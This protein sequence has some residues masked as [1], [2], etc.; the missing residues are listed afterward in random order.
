M[1]QLGII[2]SSFINLENPATP[3]HI[4]GLGLYDPATAP[5]GFV[6]F[7]DVLTN[8]D[9]RLSQ[10]PLFR[11]RLVEVAGG[12]DRPYWIEDDSYDVEFHIRHIA[13]PKPGD[14]R[15]LWI[16]VARLHSRPL[17]M[18][19]PLW[20]AYVIE[21]LDNIKGLP[22]GAFAIYTKMHHSLVDGSGGA[23][24]ISVI[25]DL[26]PA[27]NYPDQTIRVVSDRQPTQL[28]LVSRSMINRF[29]NAKQSATGLT[30][31][32]GKAARYG[33]AVAKNEKQVA[34]TA[35]KTRFN[36]RVG[37]H[38]VADAFTCE[39]EDLK[40]IK[41]ATG[42]T[43]NDVCLTIVSGGMRNYLAE[44]KEL[45]IDSLVAGIPLDMRRRL[46][47]NDDKNQVGSTFT[48]MHTNIADPLERL[49]AV[50]ASTQT[51]KDEALDNPMLEMISVP[52][53]IAPFFAKPLARLWR[54][55]NISDFIPLNISTVVTNVPGPNFPLYCAGAE[56]VRYHGLGLLTP[57]CGLF[58]TIFSSNGM[59][60]LTVLADRG[61]MPDPEIYINCLRDAFTELH[62]A[63]VGRLPG[64]AP[65]TSRNVKSPNEKSSSAAAIDSGLSKR[66]KTETTVKSPRATAK[67]KSASVAT[68]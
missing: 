34:L 39:L 37:P 3:Q 49:H 36:N 22:K 50:K 45:P 30:S 19:R 31:R 13:L 38:R 5:D 2:D 42:T 26:V 44:K 55:N 14:W 47:N 20:E 16:Q 51:A 9:E 12:L 61:I 35:P 46:G 67:K 59:V 53:A 15:Q 60:T 11:T 68:N 63:A 33:V 66:R 25:H 41:N 18:T 21:G 17:D 23:S 7:K 64:A 27:P 56:M 4:G 32:I 57:G 43:V 24:F 54:D 10:S 48:A 28:E 40:R 1:K 29:K 65:A 52:G 62:K 6:R 8:F 58:H